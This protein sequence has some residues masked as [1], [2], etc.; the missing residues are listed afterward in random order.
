MVVQAPPLY[1]Q[2]KVHPRV[3]IDDLVKSEQWGVKSEEQG[4]EELEDF[5]AILSHGR[6]GAVIRGCF[7]RATW[8]CGRPARLFSFRRIGNR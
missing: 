6:L 7:G 5:H 4:T 3:L 8:E 2:E 1:I